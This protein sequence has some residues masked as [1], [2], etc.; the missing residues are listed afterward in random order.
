MRKTLLFLVLMFSSMQVHAAEIGITYGGNVHWFDGSL[1][2]G[3]D[4]R[5]LEVEVTK[6]YGWFGIGLVGT[7]IE[8]RLEKKKFV[9]DRRYGGV[10]VAPLFSVRLSARRQLFREVYVLPFIGLGLSCQ[11][12]YPEFGDSGAIGHFGI[13]VGRRLKGDWFLEYRVSHWSDP[14]RHHDKGHNFQCL[15]L[16]KEW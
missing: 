7:V 8:S 4:S 12:H 1:A 3:I 9:R 16:G 13:G 2:E 5:T 14:F 15:R 10:E 11:N 6:R